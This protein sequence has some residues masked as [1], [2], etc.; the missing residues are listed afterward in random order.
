MTVTS[1]NLGQ[2]QTV[3]TA[4]GDMEANGKVYTTYNLACNDGLQRVSLPAHAHDVGMR[5]TYR[6]VS[7]PGSALKGIPGRLPRMR[8]V[9]L[10]QQ[11][12]G[13]VFSALGKFHLEIKIAHALRC[14]VL[15][16]CPGR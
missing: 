1:V 10:Y 12:P 4:T 8:F 2:D 15:P 9:K 13:E 11:R 3:I 16:T 6:D 5:L 7:R 14:I